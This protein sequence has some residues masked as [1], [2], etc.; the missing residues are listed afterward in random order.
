MSLFRTLGV[1]LNFLPLSV[2]NPG[3]LTVAAN[4]LKAFDEISKFTILMALAGVGLNTDLSS[5]RRLGLKPLIIGTCVAAVI[6]ILSLS[7]ILF[8]PLGV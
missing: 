6:A 5:L 8:T 4:V 2:S 1:A 3:D 7:L